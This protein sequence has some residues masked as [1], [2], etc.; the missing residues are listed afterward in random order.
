LFAN[1]S[2]YFITGTTKSDIT[3]WSDLFLEYSSTLMWKIELSTN[4]TTIDGR[5]FI[6]QTSIIAYVNQPPQPGTCDIDPKFGT[7]SDLFNIYCD[8]WSDS[9]GGNVNYTFYCKFCLIF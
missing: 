7:T 2:Y 9:E 3:L 4:I 8:K 6:G 5:N 1:S